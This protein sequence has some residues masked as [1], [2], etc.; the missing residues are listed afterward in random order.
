MAKYNNQIKEVTMDGDALIS[1]P[2]EDL[3]LDEGNYLVVLQT[4]GQKLRYMIPFSIARTENEDLADAFMIYFTGNSYVAREGLYEAEE[5][6]E[7]GIQADFGTTNNSEI[8]C[9]YLTCNIYDS[10][11][12]IV[13]HLADRELMEVIPTKFVG[14]TNKMSEGNCY[15]IF[16]W[17]GKDDEG[18]PV[19][20]GTYEVIVQATGAVEDEQSD[21]I[22]VQWK[23]EE[24][25]GKNDT[26]PKETET[27]SEN[28]RQTESETK[29][30]PVTEPETEP[31]TQRETLDPTNDS[32]LELELS[33]KRLLLP[34]EDGETGVEILF[35]IPKAGKVDLDVIRIAGGKEE[36]VRK[37]LTGQSVSKQNYRISWDGIVDGRTNA[38]AGI[39][40]FELRYT[41]GET[42]EQI[43]ERSAQLQ[44]VRS[45]EPMGK[46][47][48]DGPERNEVS[49]GTGQN[50]AVVQPSQVTLSVGTK[51]LSKA[52]IG[53]KEKV[54]L[55]ASLLP[56][57]S[58]GTVT[59]SSSNDKVATVSASGQIVGK[60]AGKAVIT[61]TT[62]N[63]KTASVTVT[64]KNAP[65]KITLS[66]KKKTLKVGKTFKVKV[67]FPAKTASYKITYTSSKKS[68]ATV[69]ATGKIKALKK[70]K[71]VITAK[72]FNGKK[73]KI[74]ITVK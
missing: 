20:D 48:P 70:G 50:T 8:A 22:K 28:S 52:T 14:S 36:T 34:L 32:V 72:T 66:A 27:E 35:S 42:G 39:Y 12:T 5:G 40:I 4:Q 71:A 29:P 56:A 60:K 51:T 21:T 6:K 25:T 74:T 58:Q 1:I 54:Q 26:D 64:V 55:T 18:N 3:E 53:V 30:E 46:E 13:R 43:K 47:K 67:K 24:N 57:G 63:G 31:E 45:D 59:Y 61:A 23:S 11:G 7:L 33:K 15:R 9:P 16:Y 69:D 73:A 19:P 65:K 37:M 49:A 68:V 62:S 44:V 17:D 41:D 10:E 38:E 2:L